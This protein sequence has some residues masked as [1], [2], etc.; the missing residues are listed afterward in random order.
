MR[1][2]DTTAP[3]FC[4]SPVMS[5][6]LQPLPSRWAAMPS[7]APMVTTPVPPMPVTR[8]PY[9]AAVDASVGSV[10]AG[11]SPDATFCGLRRLPPTTDTKL[12]QEPLTQEKSLLHELRSVVRLGP[13]A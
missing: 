13:H 7:S 10:S 4:A 6:T 8:M 9:G 12:G 11:N 1:T 2:C 5:S 3:F